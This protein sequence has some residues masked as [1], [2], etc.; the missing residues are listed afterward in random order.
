MRFLKILSGILVL[1]AA[2]YLSGPNPSTPVY[3]TT[4]PELPSNDSALENYILLQES[5]HK[6]KPD[7]E[8]R[9]VWANDSLKQPTE[10]AIVYLHGFSASQEEGNPVHRKIAQQF[11]CN[12]YLARLAEHGIDTSD[13]L[14]NMTA[15]NLWESAKE[16]YA[17]G[18]KIG[19]KVILMGTSTG[20]TLALQLAANY[21]EIAGLVLYSPN[22]EIND[23]NAWLLNNPW[24]LQIARK[25]KGSN[26]NIIPKKSDTYKQYWNQ[27]YRLEAL[28]QLE[29]LLETTMNKS[30]F[31]KIKQPV[32]ALYYYKDENNQ[33]PVVKVSAIKKMMVSLG[34][35]VEKEKMVAI[36]NAGNHVLASPI[37]S[38][39]ILSVEKETALFLQ[40]IM[41][42]TPLPDQKKEL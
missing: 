3:N 30:N 15:E 11:G 18:Q 42:L 34:T 20:G 22:I 8:A 33:D 31:E 29:E 2:V 38:K 21:P 25:V 39:D 24:G 7:N 6:I 1:L 35:P 10:Y 4:L 9:I 27:E 26:Y 5:R 40:E 23:P 32:L 17:I 36:P 41:H 19:K 37:Q 16:A 13:A 14:V 28:V 12:L